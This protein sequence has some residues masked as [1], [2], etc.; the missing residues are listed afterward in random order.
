MTKPPT[1]DKLPLS[2]SGR[3]WSGE[4]ERPHLPPWLK[5]RLPGDEAYGKVAGAIREGSLRTVCQSARCPNLAECWGR[6]TATFMI[7]GNICT[8]RCGFCAVPW[9]SPGGAYDPGEADR[10]ARAVVRLGIRH[11]VVTSVD[12]DDLA[13]GGSE[14]FALVIRRVREES[15]GTTVEVLTPDFGGSREAVARVVAARPEIF[16]HNLETVPR[17]YRSARP[18]SRYE[19]SLGVLA[20][21]RELGRGPA[22]GPAGRPVFL[23]KT[24]L[25]LGLGETNDEVI[26]VMAEAERAGVGIVTLGQY[27]QPS[28][29]HLPVA[30]FVPPQ[31]FQEL[32]NEGRRLGLGHVEAGPL[33]RSS[34]LA[35]THL[36]RLAGASRP[37]RA[38]DP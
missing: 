2:R 18:G 27:L 20:A 14:L 25:M 34:Y 3:L 26:A 5:I 29:R 15:P 19:R 7:L 9:G 28:R 24:S 13:D 22:D 4:G 10:V 36:A 1:S 16:A 6:G 32:A 37:P 8:R 17:L 23:T 38:T 33:V 35:E 21:A 30:R 12:R 31:E 11:A